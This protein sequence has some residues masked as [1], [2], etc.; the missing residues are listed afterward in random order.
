VNDT[1]RAARSR[2]H[3]LLRALTVEERL[4]TVVRLSEAVRDMALAG[5]Y[6]AHPEATP[7]QRSALL[8]ERLYGTDVARRLYG[9]VF[10]QVR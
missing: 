5:I 4:G 10:D 6:Q 7:E 1:S 3:E 9:D 2:Y 8:A